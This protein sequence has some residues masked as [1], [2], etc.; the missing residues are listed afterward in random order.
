MCSRESKEASVA[1]VEVW[2]MRSK[3]WGGHG[4]RAYIV[5]C[6]HFLFILSEG[7]IGEFLAE[8]SDRT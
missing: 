7:T 8:T 4:F 2:V 1:G 5:H 3:G 6:T